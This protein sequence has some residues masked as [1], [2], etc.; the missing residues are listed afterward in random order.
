MVPLCRAGH[1]YKTL[2]K[3]LRCLQK[4]GEFG[5]PSITAEN[6]GFCVWKSMASLG[7]TTSE[8]NRNLGDVLDKDSPKIGSKVVI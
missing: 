5:Q 4:V 2:V 7:N 6:P 1:V 3:R 8:L